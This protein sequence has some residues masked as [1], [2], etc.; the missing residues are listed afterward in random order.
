MKTVFLSFSLSICLHM[1]FPTLLP[2][3]STSPRMCVQWTCI[4]DACVCICI[5]YNTQPQK[6][7]GPES[8]LSFLHMAFSMC[9]CALKYV[10]DM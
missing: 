5:L 6:C 4:H 1:L 10:C 7:T 8:M 9:E 2:F 3:L